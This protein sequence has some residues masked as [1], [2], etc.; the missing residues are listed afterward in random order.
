[1]ALEIT[2]NIDLYNGVTLSSVYGRTT[3][4]VNDSSSSVSIRVQYWK[5]ELSY[6]N[7]LGILTTN[8]ITTKLSSY[9][10]DVDGSDVLSFT[11][12]VIKT[13]LEGL[14]YSVVISEL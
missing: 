10:R 14:G 12:Q 9:N 5:D 2:G 1:M 6:E 8:L 4:K 11:Q 7:N 13:E 3:Y